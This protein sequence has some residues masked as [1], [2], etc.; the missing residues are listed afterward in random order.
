MSRRSRRERRRRR[1]ARFLSIVAVVVVAVVT[2]AVVLTLKT[3][4]MSG[5]VF[6]GGGSVVGLVAP[7]DTPL[8]TD[9]DG[10]VNVLIFGTSQDDVGHSQGEGGQG[11]WLTDAIQV[12]S[13]DPKTG[14]AAMVAIPRD[15][16]VKVT[17]T[18]IVGTESKIN[19]IYECATGHFETLQEKIPDY[20]AVDAT[21]AQALAAAVGS[22][23]GLVPQYWVHVNYTV[24]STSVDAVGGI[25]VEIVGNGHEGIFDTGL[26]GAGCP[27]EAVGCRRVYY[28]RDGVYHIDGQ[29]AL[30][31]ARARG[32][33][34]ARSCMNFGLNGGDF[35]RQA[36]Q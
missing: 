36:N 32:D 2:V 18:C 15:T 7:A 30:D 12:L 9:A 29:H 3:A 23:T 6:G 27:H 35:D 25:D 13:I 28:P 10:R 5:K 19:A 22:V 34:Q 21:G 1:R 31:L 26:D 11:M 17:G 24:L 20:Q 14:T 4:A 16:W 33:V 8:K